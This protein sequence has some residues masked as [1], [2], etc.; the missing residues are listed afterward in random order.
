MDPLGPAE[1]SRRFAAA[2]VWWIATSS[3]DD[4]PHTVPVWGVVVDGLLHTYADPGARRVRDLRADPRVVV[5]LES[6][7]DVLIVRGTATVGGEVVEHPDVVAAYAQAYPSPED[8]A[9]LPGAPEMAGVVLVTVRPESA[10][11]WSLDD[12]FASQRRWSA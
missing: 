11:A 5:H 8:A 6:G 4:G 12:F 7:S 10:L 2:P 3:A 9:F 1:I